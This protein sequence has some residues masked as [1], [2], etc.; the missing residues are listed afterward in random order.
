MPLLNVALNMPDSLL[1]ELHEAA[2]TSHM[3]PEVFAAEA[4]E[5]V[6]ATRRLDRITDPNTI[7]S[8]RMPEYNE[9]EGK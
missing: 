4:I 9:T 1:S 8:P 2:R 7:T 5:S 6:L 3:R